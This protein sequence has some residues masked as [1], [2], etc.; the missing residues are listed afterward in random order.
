M[1][2]KIKFIILGLI[3]A[4]LILTS[5]N[6]LS[7]ILIQKEIIKPPPA[8]L[9][10]DGKEHVSGVG[11]Y[12]W[13]LVFSFTCADYSGIPTPDE[14]LPANSP[15]MGHLI[16]PLEEIPQEIQINAIR[17][18]DD[19][20]IESYQN[21]SF[22]WH[23]KEGHMQEGNYSTLPPKRESDIKLS[24]EPGIYILEVHPIWKEKGSVCYG[25]LLTV[26]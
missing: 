13:E 8:I 26:Q 25:F 16:L 15:F 5:V 14:P 19:D 1:N 20:K 21:G 2:K 4:A 6:F 23:P 7:N 18:T 12:C 11:S 24:L 9:K 17:V 22:M 10:L 3:L